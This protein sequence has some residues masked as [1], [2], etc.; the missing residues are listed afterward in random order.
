MNGINK[1]F[2]KQEYL[3]TLFVIVISIIF[4]MKSPQFLT[5]GNLQLILLQTSVNLICVIGIVMVICTGNIELSAGA[6]LAL[7]G[8]VGGM[9]INKGYSI[10]FVLVVGISIGVL[11]GFM[12]GLLVTKLGLPSIIA[13]IA[14][15]YLIRG[16]VLM[17]TDN[18]WINGFPDSFTYWGTGRIGS[19]PIPFILFLLL[20]V[21]FSLIMRY[22]N[23]GR[24]IYAVGTSKDASEKLGINVDKVQ[25]IA[26]VISGGL[27]GLGGLVYSASVGVINPPSTGLPLGTQLLAGALAGGVNINGGKGTILGASIGVIMLGL[28]RNGLILSRVSEFWIDAITGAIIL[29]ALALNVLDTMNSR[30]KETVLN[31]K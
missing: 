28:V 31:D 18:R 30:R 29:I 27:I 25:I 6:I 19:I 22:T 4:S 15:N 11:C 13:T 14:T 8:A 9:L 20:A 16:V 3:I 12:N 17:V 24:K 23:L 26:F 5:K 21:I 1:L 10:P 7:S 2:K